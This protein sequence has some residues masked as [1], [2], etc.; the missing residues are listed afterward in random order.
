MYDL[1]ISHV[2]LLGQKEPPEFVRTKEAME[3]RV[4]QEAVG[5]FPL[6]FKIHL[7]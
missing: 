1:L 3:I 7:A 6:C 4:P 2:E 5:Q